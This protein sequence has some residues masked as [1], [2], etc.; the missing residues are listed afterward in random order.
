ML[1]ISNDHRTGKVFP[2]YDVR[3]VVVQD[4]QPEIFTDFLTYDNVTGEFVPCSYDTISPIINNHNYE[5]DQIILI[6]YAEYSSFFNSTCCNIS[7][8]AEAQAFNDNVSTMYRSDDRSFIASMHMPRTHRLLTSSW[9]KNNCTENFYYTQSWDSNETD[10]IL[11]C[12]DFIRGIDHNFSGFLPKN[13]IVDTRISTHNK[14]W[15]YAQTVAPDENHL[16]FNEN[17]K[18]LF[19]N[20]TTCIITEP[21][22][23]EYAP[24]YSEKYLMALYGYC[25]PIFVGMWHGALA[26]KKLGF[27][28]FDDVIDHSYETELDPAKRTLLAL[29]LNR[30]ILIDHRPR[31]QDYLKRHKNNFDI[32][33]SNLQ[34][35]I[36]TE[37]NKLFKIKHSDTIL[38]FLVSKE[39]G[40]LSGKKLL[41]DKIRDCD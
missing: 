5:Y 19:Y 30:D 40:T 31:K 27:D 39:I 12:E 11:Q 23:F 6:D 35:L 17:L 13:Y 24:I 14:P 8:L 9:I 1:V 37:L 26:A 29:E 2:E 38:K 33:T 15:F 7:F 41:R 34:T 4:I 20:S 3:T 18:Y 10:L 36:D 25:F 32:V 21:G 16:F 22:I 28:T